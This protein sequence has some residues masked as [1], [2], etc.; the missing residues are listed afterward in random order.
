MALKQRVRGERDRVPT[1]WR[2]RC[3]PAEE[4][5][6]RF[7]VRIAEELLRDEREA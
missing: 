2:W 5:H 7:L 4:N 1:V 3:L 6:L